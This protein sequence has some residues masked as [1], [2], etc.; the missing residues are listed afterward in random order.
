MP[1]LNLL[2]MST[3]VGPLGSGLGG[4]VE[5]TLLNMAQGLQS[6]GHQIQVVAP[7]GSQLPLAVEIQQVEGALQ[8]PAQTQTRDTPITMPA[9]A[10]L[11]NMWEFSRQVQAEYDLIV[12]FAYDWLPFYLTPY[13][14][15]AIAHWV[16]MGSL[17]DALDQMAMRVATH[18]P[19]TIGVYTQTQA[20]TFPFADTCY[21]LGSGLDLSLYDYCAQPGDAL[22]WL[23]RIAPE[24]GLEDAVAAVAQLGIPLKIMGQIQ[25]P[26]YWQQI[27]TRFPDAPITYL[28]FLGTAEMQSVLRQ[29]R[30]LLVTSRWV[31][32]FGNVLI[33]ALACGVPVIAYARGGP[34]EIVRNGKTGWLVEPD[35]VPGLVLA[36]QNL[37]QIDRAAC[38]QQAEAEYSLSA[39]GDRTEQWLYQVKGNNK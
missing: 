34:T 18:Y 6:R 38:R 23:G 39:L 7:Q 30:G 22:C 24:K 11:G 20:A 36:I 8:V 35:S 5:L 12:N 1:P 25:D 10:V 14:E 32:A 17:S 37:A 29:C 31:E 15:T 33:E 4:G 19:D 13:F 2:F 9:N 21:L 3:P 27:Q 16:S 28:G 26:D